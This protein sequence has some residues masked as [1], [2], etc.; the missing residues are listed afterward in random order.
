MRG[1]SEEGRLF[2]GSEGSHEFL[3][4]RRPFG[5]EVNPGNKLVIRN[6][7]PWEH[8][9]EEHYS[10]CGNARH[11]EYKDGA[12]RYVCGGHSLVE[13]AVGADGEPKHD[14]VDGASDAP[15]VGR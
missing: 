11:L 9:A 7:D 14:E 6:W 2:H 4:V 5:D 12:D 15:A 1:P 10:F 8:T 13:E 3:V